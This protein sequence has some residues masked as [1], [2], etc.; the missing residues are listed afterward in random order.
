MRKI[1]I[2]VLVL[3]GCRAYAQH[4]IQA[5]V[6]GAESG[7]LIEM[8][9]VRLLSARDS[10][11]VKGVQTDQRGYFTLDKIQNGNYVLVVSFVGY[12]NETRN[13]SVKGKNLLLKTIYMKEDVALLGEVEVKG[14]AAQMVVR[15]D[16]TEYNAAAFKTAEN[17][18]V[19]ELLKKMPGVEVDSDGKITVNGEEI[20]KVR[21]DGKKFFDDDPQMA[22]KNIPAEMIDKVQVLDEKSEMAKLTGFEDDETERIINLTLKP[23]RKRGVFGNFTGGVGMDAVKGDDDVYDIRYNANMFLNMMLNESQTSIVGGANNTNQSRSG[24]GR[25]NINASSGITNTQNLGVNT[26]VEP[27]TQLKVGGDATV[28][29][30]TNLTLSS[31]EQRTYSNEQDFSNYDNSQRVSN[32]YDANMRLELEWQIDSMN[33]LIVQP[34]VSYT[35]SLLSTESDYTYFTEGDSISWGNSEN[36][37]NQTSIEGGGRIIYNHKFKKAGR[38]LTGNVDIRM[39]DSRTDG[40][41][42]SEK[43]VSDGNTQEIIDQQ[44]SQNSTSFRYD[45]RVSYVEP[46]FGNKHFLEIA[47]GMNTNLRNSEKLQYSQ[48]AEGNYTQLDSVYSNNFTNRFFSETLELNYRLKDKTYD[49][50]I[51]AKAN[52]SQTYSHTIYGN[53]D[54]T[55]VVNKVWNFAPTASF[56]YTFGKREFLRIMYRGTTNQPSVEQMEPSRNN[57]DPMNERVGNLDLKP[58]FNQSLRLMYSKFNQERFSSLSAGVSGQLTKDALV[59]NSIYD[60]TGKRYYQT[61]NA[62]DMPFSV[63]A[64]V[65]YNTPLIQK[66]LHFNTQTSLSFSRQV[67]YTLTGLSSEAIDTEQLL[68]GDLS[69]NNNLGGNEYLSLTFTHDIVEVGVQ[70]KF[71]YSRTQNNLSTYGITHIYDWTTTGSLTFHL[72][73]QFTLASDIGYT[74]RYGYNLSDIN[75]LIWNASLDKTLLKNRA[76]LSLKAYDILNQRKN[77]R[78]TIGDNYVQY[79]V[80]NTLPTYVMLSFTYKL[81][82]MGGNARMRD[83]EMPPPDGGPG[84]GPRGGMPGGGPPPERPF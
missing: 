67:G 43:N 46:L 62:V 22:T 44:V 76:T 78:E 23:N 5:Q 47:A 57:S 29:H 7:E 11:L 36:L 39:S 61:V 9:T 16:T 17:A 42:Y 60:E 64:H 79:S 72:P 74:A 12:H 19:E 65:M 50:M 68:L 53:A 24:R 55:D 75:E 21:V 81:N 1:L 73:G 54:Q 4:R 70:G 2:A 51:G 58:S 37:S 48:D 56:R 83:G 66:R 30:S 6:V 34:R 27:N 33:T 49:L 77:I 82:K 20:T 13:I 71:T 8:A 69:R 3:F 80:Y 26:F 18:V 10:S 15:G 41:N 32:N 25:T 84:D 38:T 45:V 31:V 28:N 63:S 40:V 52:P 35:N 59:S 14:T